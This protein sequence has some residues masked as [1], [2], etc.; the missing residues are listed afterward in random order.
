[1]G[2]LDPATGLPAKLHLQAIA[3][4]H[5][6]AAPAALGQPVGWSE[7]WEEKSLDELAE[8]QGIGPVYSFNAL[9]GRGRDLWESDAEVASF[10]RE[11]Y[12]WRAEDALSIWT[13]SEGAEDDQNPC[14]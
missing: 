7:F 2:E 13:A 3:P 1:M 5:G 12:Q 14:T 4:A 6:R 9:F 11:I 8:K 10:V